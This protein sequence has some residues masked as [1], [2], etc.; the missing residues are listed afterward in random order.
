M[1]AVHIRRWRVLVL[2]VKRKFQHLP[3]GVPLYVALW[4]EAVARGTVRGVEASLVL[5][6][7]HRMRGA[8][9]RLG[10]TIYKTY[11]TYEKVLD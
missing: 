6:D 11:R 8:L 9:E 2:G 7:N 5:E 4:N 10:G 3:L 1:R